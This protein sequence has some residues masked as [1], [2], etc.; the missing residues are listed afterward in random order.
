MCGISHFFIAE[1]IRALSVY[2]WKRR[3]VLCLIGNFE[4]AISENQRD[5]PEEIKPRPVP[6]TGF[7]EKLCVFLLAL[8]QTCNAVMLS[9]R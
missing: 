4:P 7:S 2:W 5:R 9:V 6:V 1:L 8:L 3:V